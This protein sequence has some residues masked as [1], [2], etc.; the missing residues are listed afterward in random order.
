MRERGVIRD[1]TGE[2]DI[3]CFKIISSTGWDWFECSVF[4]V[5]RT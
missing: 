4:T 3:G 2:I 1:A 5:T